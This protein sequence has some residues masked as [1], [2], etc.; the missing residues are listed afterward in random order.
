VDIHGT[1][2]LLSKRLSQIYIPHYEQEWNATDHTDSK[3]NNFYITKI[4]RTKAFKWA[5]LISSVGM[6][7][8][9]HMQ[10]QDGARTHHRTQCN[11]PR[12]HTGGGAEM[13][14]IE[15]CRR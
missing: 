8:N 7:M 2:T 9:T 15:M 3:I 10:Q 14:K 6:G 11:S 1:T 13:Q 4:I 12:T 5:N